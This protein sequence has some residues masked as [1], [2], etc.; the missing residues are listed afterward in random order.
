L[1]S[2]D[3]G[4]GDESACDEVADDF[5]LGA[6]CLYGGLVG[7]CRTRARDEGAARDGRGHDDDRSDPQQPPSRPATR[8][9]G[10]RV[11]RCVGWRLIYLDGF[12]GDDHGGLLAGCCRS[13]GAS[14]RCPEPRGGD[15]AEAVTDFA[16]AVSHFAWPLL[17]ESA[18]RGGGS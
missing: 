1:G 18:G 11:E 13:P 14:G 5:V 10:P 17:S 15:F 16:T 3:G 2:V 7:P 12:F 4:G 8:G 6:W 9:L